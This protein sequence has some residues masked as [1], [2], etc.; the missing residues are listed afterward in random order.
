M[1]VLLS[2]LLVTIGVTT[3]PAVAFAQ[4]PVHHRMSVDPTPATHRVVVS[5]EVQLPAG[6]DPSRGFLL[7]ATLVVTSATPAVE[8]VALG[9]TTP[10]FGNNG[11]SG[12]LDPR[13][14]KRYRFKAAP[15]NGRVRVD[16]AGALDFELS[17]QKEEYTRGFR[18]TVGR[19]GEEG[20][21]LAGRTFWYPQFGD[22]L[23]T[24]DIDA[25]VP[26]GWHLV[27]QGEGTSR[28]AQGRA[29]WKTS[30]PMDEIYLVGG[31]LRVW[32]DRAG[33]V[34]SLVYL[35]Q[36]DPALASKYLAATA[37]YIEMYRALV[38]PY[39]YGKFALVENF[40]ETGYGMPS[41]TLLGPQIIRFPW[42]LTSSY[43]H[44]ILH[45]WWGNSV[46]VDYAS[47]N[48]CEGLT[49]YLADH[50]IQEQRGKGDEYRRG[51]LQRYR[52]YVKE[53][54]DFPLTEFRSRES[55]ATEAIGY[56]KTLMGMHMLRRRLGDD[57][58]RTW[59]ARLYR[60]FRGKRATFADLQ[61]TAEAVAGQPLDA[62]F[63]DWVRRPGA[64]DL[65]VEV[66]GVRRAGA[67]FLVEGALVQRQSDA[68]YGLDVPMAVQTAAGT[69]VHV[70]PMRAKREPF[71]IAADAEPLALVVDPGFDLFR[72]L[73][74]RETPSSI[75]QIFGEPRATAVL[76]AKAAPA[77]LAAYR[78]LAEGWRSDSHQLSLVL[79]S[80]IEDLPKDQAVWVIGR[81]NRFAPQVA[82][83]TT[84]L[85]VEG[86]AVTLDGERV[87][88][89]GHTI[90]VTTRHPSNPE[91][92]LGWIL[93]DPQAAIPGLGR[94]LPHYGRY[95]YL[96]FEGEEPTNTVKGEWAASD[97]PLRVDLRPDQARTAK[98]PALTLPATKALAELPPVFSEKALR[99]HVGWLA[100]PDREGRGV[101]TKG[102]EAA[103]T[104]V[105]EQFKAAGLTPGGDNGGW[106]QA[107]AVPGPGGA[108]QQTSNVIGVLAGTKAD[109]RGQTVLVTAHYDHLGRGG[110]DSRA[111][112]AGQVHPGADDNASGV[113]VLI[114]LARVIAAGDKPERTIVFVA[115][116]G[117]E[118]G[119]AGS[120]Y[121]ADHP[122]PVPLSGVRG[123]INLDTVGRLGSGKVSILGAG[124]ATEW[125][126]IFRGAS[127]VTGVDSQSVSGNAEASDQRTFLERGIPAVQIFTGPHP[128]Y[129]R[130]SDTADKVDV[131]GLV[132]VATLVREG[133]VYLAARPEPLTTTIAPATPP[134]A[135]TPAAA[136]AAPGQAQGARRVTFGTVPDFAFEGPGLK[137]SGVTA[138]SGAEKAGLAAGDIIVKVAD[139]PITSLRDFSDVLKTLAPGQAVPV[140]YT[141]DGKEQAATV[142][143][144]ER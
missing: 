71:S 73:D 29:H 33:A 36:D 35:R 79:D 127:F 50:L 75:G 131:A 49:A 63:A 118:S 42:I 85:K 126:H 89:T 77:L 9:D 6:A 95:S 56:G 7:G 57:A 23:V 64:A 133:V 135:G 82:K 87:P 31:P 128:D 94:K 144:G 97:S 48:W 12:A 137:L 60:D 58:F 22:D 53:S 142:T 5:D 34:E 93:A 83:A 121:F 76:P 120:R 69:T 109:W 62:F 24:F 86:E 100:S 45:N 105:A 14:V 110:A 117:E 143:V 1:R 2:A 140:V 106:L 125:P 102:G 107:F 52:D 19:L 11:T 114:E 113:A 70:V 116:S 40:W 68:A 103:A 26:E 27:S 81:E 90:V 18:E 30:A 124:S 78:T 130:P 66:S 139:R 28:D 91:K 92:A 123:V 25:R 96:A 61:N 108:P 67:G 115:F 84:S 46:F 112:D 111:G 59:L 32:R 17:A 99:D 37:Q 39:P 3:S 134:A 141:R 104:Y 119:L 55:A 20:I 72:R 15:V 43:P 74:P 4:A 16:Y 101:G 13:Q 47:G 21:Y 51:T 10:F 38:G 8:E 129:H 98:L 132:K 41:F 44:E 54:R 88:M 80:A 122:L 138:G 136:P 65:A